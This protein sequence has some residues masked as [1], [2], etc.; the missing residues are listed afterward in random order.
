MK[1]ATFRL[2]PSS[3]ISDTAMV[4]TA[5]ER[6]AP[7]GRC[8]VCDFDQAGD[9]TLS[10]VAAL[11]DQL[12]FPSSFIAP[13]LECRPESGLCLS[14]QGAPFVPCGPRRPHGT[15]VAA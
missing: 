8:A 15:A 4:A 5:P 9:A 11:R 10:G 3:K 1:L 7:D 12:C 2:P 6:Y 14:R 13:N